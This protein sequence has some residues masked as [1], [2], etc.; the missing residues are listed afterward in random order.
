[1][2]NKIQPQ[3]NSKGSGMGSILH[4]SDGDPKL[5]GA[6]RNGNGRRLNAYYD[7]RAYGFAFVVSQI[8]SFLS[9]LIVRRVL[10]CEASVPAS[11][12]FANLVE[13]FRESDIFI[14]V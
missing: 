4:N 14:S 7:N 8:F 11:E 1:M 2:P 5:L 10:F 12:H 13:F 3:E 6:N 9:R